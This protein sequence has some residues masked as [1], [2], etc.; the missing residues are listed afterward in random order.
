MKKRNVHYWIITIMSIFSIIL[1]VFSIITVI[2]LGK[3]QIL[4]K[5][6]DTKKTIR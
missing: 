4:I 2:G 5:M 6:D 3:P 1:L